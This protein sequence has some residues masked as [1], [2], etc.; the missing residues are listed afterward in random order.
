MDVRKASF[1]LRAFAGLLLN[2]RVSVGLFKVGA[3]AVLLLK[4]ECD[5]R[6]SCKE[7]S[8]RTFA[9]VL[10]YRMSLLNHM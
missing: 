9:S 10:P 5:R 2:L 8:V 7:L 3:S 6:A 1:L 4:Y